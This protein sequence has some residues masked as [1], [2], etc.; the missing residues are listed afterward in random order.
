MSCPCICPGGAAGTILRT[1]GTISPRPSARSRA[2]QLRRRATPAPPV[3]CSWG[4]SATLPIPRS[5][6]RRWRRSAP[7][8]LSSPNSTTRTRGSEAC[9]TAR[10]STRPMPPLAPRTPEPRG[11]LSAAAQPSARNLLRSATSSGNG[12]M[13]T[14]PQG[15]FL[16]RTAM[17]G[18]V[19][20]VFTRKPSEPFGST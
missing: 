4:C 11:A 16:I 3:F 19:S 12:S 15:S 13:G 18:L 6:A 8:C 1:A 14:L 7:I 20:V 5:P 9:R 2:G 17:S 10:R